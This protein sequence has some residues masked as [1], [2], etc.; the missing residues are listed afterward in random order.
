M[1]KLGRNRAQASIPTDFRGTGLVTKHKDL[2]NRYY[3]AKQDAKPMAF[4]S[5]KW[6]SA[7]ESIEAESAKKCAY[8]EAPTKTVAWGDVEH[9][10]PK[11]LYW[12]LAYCF[13]NYLFA[14][15]ICNQGFKGDN[16][17]VVGAKL[18][19]PRMPVKAPKDPALTA[20][21]TRLARD[22]TA[23]TDDDILDEWGHEKAGLPHPY[24][25]DPAKLFVFEA[26]D[27]NKEVWVKARNTA[28]GRSAF[29]ACEDYLGLNREELRRDRYIHYRQLAVFKAVLEDDG[30]RAATRTSISDELERMQRADYPF[31]GM[32][33]YFLTE[34]GYA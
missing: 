14:C 15:Q 12:W 13:D 16:F 22:V 21:A 29:K 26:D 20:L 11:S 9:F 18:R 8:C 27:D 1:I 24:Y 23:I 10:R 4:V 2:I 25:E 31:A 3:V 19:A 33:R 34:W 30:V 5:G 7:K 17:P 6:K 28:R 32:H